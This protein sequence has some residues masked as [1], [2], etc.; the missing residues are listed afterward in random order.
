MKNLKTLLFSFIFLAF[1]SCESDSDTEITNPEDEVS[2]YYFIQRTLNNDGSTFSYSTYELANNRISSVSSSNMQSTSEYFYDNG[3]ISSILN[4][5]SGTLSA[6][7]TFSYDNN[8]LVEYKIEKYNPDAINKIEKHTFLHT[9]DTIFSEYTYSQDG[10][11]YQL[12][13]QSKIKLVNDNRVYFEEAN[14]TTTDIDVSEMTYDQ[15]DNPLTETTY[16]KFDNFPPTVAQMSYSNN[17]SSYGMIMKNTFGKKNLMLLYHLQT[18][19][20]NL[21][22]VKILGN[23]NLVAYQTNWAS[24]VYNFEVTNEVNQNNYNSKTVYKTYDNNGLLSSFE[25]EFFFN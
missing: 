19:A 23:S 9:S 3:K 24:D 4:Y 8:N 2:I 25:H 10:T 16:L 12:S 22:K 6:K 11:N 13:K 1:I 18:N 21:F 15:N 7:S 17:K 14:T 5:T 20:V